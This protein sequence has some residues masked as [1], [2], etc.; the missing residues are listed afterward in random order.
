[1]SN[2]DINYDMYCSAVFLRCPVTRTVTHD[3]SER[4]APFAI[5]VQP[6]YWIPSV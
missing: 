4:K 6:I 3:R 2:T 1:M 5:K